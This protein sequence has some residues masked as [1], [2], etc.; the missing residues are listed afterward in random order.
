MTESIDQV[1]GGA[2]NMEREFQPATNGR[3]LG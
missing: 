2:E 1:A 3:D